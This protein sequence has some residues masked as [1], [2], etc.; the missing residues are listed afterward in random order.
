MRA[1]TYPHGLLRLGLWLIAVLC[2]GG[3]LSGCASGGAVEL[4]GNLDVHDPA[5]AKDGDTWFVYSTGHGTLKDGNIQ[6]RSSTD[7]TT[8]RQAGF[9]WEVEP[10]WLRE[11]VPGVD[12]LWAPE[13]YE[14]GG[15]WYLYYSASTFGKNASVIALATNTTLDPDDANYEWIDQGPVIESSSADDFNAID[16]GITVDGAGTP[17]MAFG[18]F[19]SGIRMIELSWPSGLR[20]DTAEPLHIAEREVPPNAIEAPYLLRHDGYWFLFVSLDNC[21]AG[22]DSTYKIAVGRSDSPTGPYVDREGV[23]LAKGD[24]S[25][26]LESEGD[27]IGPGGQSVADGIM[28]LHY[29]DAK[30]NG[31][32]QLGLIPIAWDDEG[33]PILTW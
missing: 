28:A 29:Y 2:V 10:Q 4:K 20:A 27:R 6:V 5:L 33:W 24:G 16:P 31:Q 32:S 18:S 17:W 30:L 14:Y 1:T 22:T 26:L 13:L 3:L 8:W 7:G 9:V 19:W 25:L 15:I 11:A 12:N 23:A 21:C